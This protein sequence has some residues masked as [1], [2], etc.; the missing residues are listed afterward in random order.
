MDIAKESRLQKFKRLFELRYLE[1]PRAGKVQI[2]R[3]CTEIREFYMSPG[4]Q[5]TPIRIGRVLLH[6]S[7]S[8]CIGFNPYST[9]RNVCCHICKTIVSSRFVRYIG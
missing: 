8:V 6:P 9:P 2:R 7:L 3:V 4:I 1:E 5:A